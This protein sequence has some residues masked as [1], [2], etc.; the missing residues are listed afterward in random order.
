[1]A[2]DFTRTRIQTEDDHYYE[3]LSEYLSVLSNPTRLKILKI[4]EKK[5]REI[6]EIAAE[7][8]LSYENTK[9]HLDKLVST[10]IVKKE[11]GLGRETVKGSLPVWKYSL[12]P[13]GFESVVRNLGVFG[14]LGLDVGDSEF[15]KKIAGLQNEILRDYNGIPVL[16]VLFGNGDKQYFPLYDASTKIGRFDRGSYDSEGAGPVWHIPAA[17]FHG[18]GA[19]IFSAEYDTITRI[20]RPHGKIMKIEGRWYYMDCGST[21][22]SYMSGDSLVPNKM[23]PL[24]DGDIIVVSRW[25]DEIRLVFS[26]QAGQ[27]D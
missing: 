19:V 18:E 6:R 11:A 8:N 4:I 13:G 25:P 20:S 24:N 2:E 16:I 27:H 3:E 23:V 9:R 15:L 5:P 10:T 7:I 22:G 14:N 17:G 26:D 21:G 1:M 12:Y